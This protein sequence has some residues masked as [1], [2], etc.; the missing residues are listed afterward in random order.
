MLRK[1]VLLKIGGALLF[2]ASA[3]AMSSKPKKVSPVYTLYYRALGGY[4]YT[5][6][7]S[8]ASNQLRTDGYG[9]AGSI[10]S[11][12]GSWTGLYADNGCS[13]PVLFYP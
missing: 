8:V 4:C 3:F 2:I 12:G 10:K 13:V 1:S 9:T 7:S 5:F 6:A 11:T